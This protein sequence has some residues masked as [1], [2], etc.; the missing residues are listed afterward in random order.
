[1]G[2]IWVLILGGA[3]S[4]VLCDFLLNGRAATRGGLIGLLCYLALVFMLVYAYWMTITT[5]TYAPLDYTPP[6]TTSEE[7]E[8]EVKVAREKEI[9]GMRDKFARASVCCPHPAAAVQQRPQ[10]VLLLLC[11]CCCT[12]LV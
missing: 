8:D 4:V 1:M 11:C 12:G 3:M 2:T 7:R 9:A 5:P 6:N 10:D